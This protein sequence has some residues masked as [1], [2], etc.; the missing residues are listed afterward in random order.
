MQE[1]LLLFF[2]NNTIS[3]NGRR[4]NKAQSQEDRK[5]ESEEEVNKN[6]NISQEQSIEQLQTKNMEVHHPP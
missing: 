3:N 4:P 6:K 5:S 2:K 1:A